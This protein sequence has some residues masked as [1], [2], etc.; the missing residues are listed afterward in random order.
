[1]SNR[2]YID[3]CAK[4][5]RIE[6]LLHQLDKGEYKRFGRKISLYKDL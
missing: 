5:G 2:L 1:M 3:R 4:G 6:S